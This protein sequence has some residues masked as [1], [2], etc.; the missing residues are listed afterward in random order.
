MWF[1]I[2][3]DDIRPWTYQY[4]VAESKWQDLNT[5]KGKHSQKHW[6][7]VNL[8]P[9]KKCLLVTW[10]LMMTLNVT[11]P[12]F[13]HGLICKGAGI[14][15][16]IITLYWFCNSGKKRR[17]FFDD[18]VG[19]C[20]CCVWAYVKWSISLDCPSQ[21]MKK[22][23]YDSHTPSGSAPPMMMI[24]YKA[25]FAFPNVAQIDDEYEKLFLR[26]QNILDKLGRKGLWLFRCLIDKVT[27]NYNLSFKH[28]FLL[29]LRGCLSK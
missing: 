26:M 12:D 7:A 2:W 18:I 14:V 29:N 11:W 13:E 19:V 28:R 25:V 15:F 23:I 6:P 27:I 17:V 16:I 8:L 22:S 21:R 4:V 9:V 5:S 24:E 10:F 1:E 20:V 3:R